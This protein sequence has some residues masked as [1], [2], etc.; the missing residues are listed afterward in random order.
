MNASQLP[1]AATRNRG[2]QKV[3]WK[4]TSVQEFQ[5]RLDVS[6]LC[7][8]F[9]SFA[10]HSTFWAWEYKLKI[11]R[12]FFTINL[13][14]GISS[15][16]LPWRER[17]VHFF[18]GFFKLWWGFVRGKC[19]DEI[20]THFLLT[21]ELMNCNLF[22]TSTEVKTNFTFICFRFWPFMVWFVNLGREWKNCDR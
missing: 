20:L 12:N 6:G 21:K 10:R 3:D 17:K 18:R 4:N 19:H 15:I 7:V 11:L 1:Q 5:S 8:D 13:S 9:L 22:S 14:L 16:Q 2:K